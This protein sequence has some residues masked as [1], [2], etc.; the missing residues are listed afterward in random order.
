MR[1]ASLP[2]RI[3]GDW[4]RVHSRV[5]VRVL[6]LAV[7]LEGHPSLDTH[8]GSRSGRTSFFSIPS[9][10]PK[11]RVC[12]VAN[13]R[14]MKSRH[15]EFNPR[16]TVRLILVSRIMRATKCR[17]ETFVMIAQSFA[18]EISAEENRSL[19][20]C[21]LKIGDRFR[22]DRTTMAVLDRILSFP[23]GYIGKPCA[24]RKGGVVEIQ[25]RKLL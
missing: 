1:S 7:E 17:G 23:G 19:I 4:R 12:I 16:L 10:A 25:K 15:A 20:S 14:R 11:R 8:P 3:D 2:S 5:V 21:Q 22:C 9:S 13:V 18:R 24:A 6:P